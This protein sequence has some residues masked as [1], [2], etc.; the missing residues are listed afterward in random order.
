MTWDIQ[1]FSETYLR[2]IFAAKQV[3]AAGPAAGQ[4]PMNVLCLGKKTSA[5]NLV[6]DSEVRQVF[7]REGCIAAA[8]EGSQLA[9]MGIAA[10]LAD[11]NC[12]LYLAAVAE[13]G[14]GTAATVTMLLATVP[15][16]DGTITVRINGKT[17]QVS[18]A[19]G[20]PIDTIGAAL[21][22]RINAQPDCPFTASYDAPTDTLTLTSRC[23]GANE[24][25]WIIYQDLSAAGGL[26]STLTGS[27]VVNTFGNA[28]GVRAGVAGGAG[29]ED[30]TAILTK[31]TA[32][33]YAR[34]AIG[35]NTS[36]TGALV[37]AFLAAQAAVTVQVYDQAIY[38]HNGTQTQAATLAQTNLNDVKEEVFAHRNSE[39]HPALIAAGWAAKRAATEGADPVPDYD[40]ADCSAWVAPTQYD[41][42]TWLATEE[43]ALLNT[44]V[45]PIKTENGVAKCVRAITTYCLNGAVQDTRCLDIGD[46]VFP[47]YAVLALFNLWDE[48]RQA[49]KYVGPDPDT[50]NGELEPQAGVAYPKLWVSAVKGLM[51]DWFKNN[52]I[53][54]TFSG[55]SPVYPVQAAYNKAAR[56][57]Q[58]NVPFVVRR[59]QHQLSVIA[60]QTA[61]A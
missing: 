31:I 48:F 9:L 52:W 15:T 46:A 19:S 60:R 4:G 26:T 41:T 17:M 37:K 29:T 57:I 14:G 54:D 21:A 40:N 12:N 42:D 20:T 55:D 49:N 11:P 34:I 8:G 10:L 28:K 36:T 23:K 3:F 5:G 45:T 30:Y 44:G 61:P 53:E 32:R 59:V 33:R 43:N 2:P 56:R 27:A 25:D 7:D 1:G 38:G 6:A 16:S 13:A 18:Y 39:T 22:A 35:D 58:S 24:K 47:D 51:T 50:D